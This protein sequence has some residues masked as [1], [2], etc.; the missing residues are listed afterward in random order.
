MYT[1]KAHTDVAY[2]ACARQ[3]LAAPDAV[4]PQ[5]ATHN[6][7]TLAAVYQLADPARY[8][9]RQYEFQC[10]H[11][12]GEPL[13]EQVVGAAD[14]QASWAGP[15]A[16]TRRWARTRRCW[17]TWCAGCWRTAPTRRS[18]NRIADPDGADRRAGDGIR[19]ERVRANWRARKARSGLPH[20]AIPLPRDLYGAG[21]A[22][23]AR[24]DLANERELARARRQPAGIG[25]R[26]LVRRPAAGA[27]RRRRTGA[28]QPVRNPADHER[29]RRARCTK[30]RPPMS[31]WRCPRH[32][33]RRRLGRHTRRPSAR[34]SCWRGADRLRGATCRA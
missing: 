30:P 33:R 29:R 18:C 13:Y 2:L 5:F 20:P 31:T 11:G 10:L 17:P 26:G 21:R 8:T 25:R 6:A 16:S 19:C 1:R 3:L 28:S 7:H 34:A 27:S 9:P 22:Q 15:A 23:L 32:A 12:M 24:L 14:A 4:Y